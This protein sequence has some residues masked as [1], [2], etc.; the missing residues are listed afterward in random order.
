MAAAAAAGVRGDLGAA[1]QAELD[2]QGERLRAAQASG[3]K[4]ETAL[5]AA[6]L[7]RIL[8]L[9]VRHAGKAPPAVRLLAYAGL[10]Y[11]AGRQGDDPRWDDMAAAVAVA[12][13]QWVALSP[14]VK[15]PALLGQMDKAIADMA[16]ACDRRDAKSAA[17][18]V[19]AEEDLVEA[20]QAWFNKA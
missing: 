15:D 7:Y 9:A 4:T 5:A 13:Q 18:A 20:L 10:R 11:N 19:R 3:D 2:A 8:S 12:R 17:R 1:A 16:A 6:E 14:Q